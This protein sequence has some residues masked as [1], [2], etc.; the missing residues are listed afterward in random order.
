MVRGIHETERCETVK[1]RVRLTT[2]LR[3]SKLFSTRDY[4]QAVRKS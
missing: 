3:F 2:I 1:I 4:A